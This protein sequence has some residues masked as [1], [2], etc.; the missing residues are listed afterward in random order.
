ML[1][2]GCFVRAFPSCSEWA[3]LFIAVHGFLIVAASLCFFFKQLLVFKKIIIHL[4]VFGCTG[5]SLLCRLFS[6]CGVQGLLSLQW[7][8]LWSVGSGV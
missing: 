6:R 4:F 8:L 2:L 1:G 5:S 7:L 3:L